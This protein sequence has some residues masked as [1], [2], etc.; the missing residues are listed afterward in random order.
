MKIK[1]AA[2][3]VNPLAGYGGIRNNKG[4]DNLHLKSIDE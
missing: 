2:F 1:R 4:S 3:F